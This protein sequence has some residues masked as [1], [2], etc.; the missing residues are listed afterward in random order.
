MYRVKTILFA[1]VALL[2]V[3]G[4][5]DE[6]ST[7]FNASGTL[8]HYSPLFTLQT[9]DEIEDDLSGITYNTE[10]K[11]FFMVRDDEDEGKIWEYDNNLHHLRT[12][13][14]KHF[15]DAEDIAYLGDDEFAIVNEAGELFIFVIDASTNTL[16][17]SD[18]NVQM[19]KFADVE[20]ENKGPEGVTYDSANKTFYIVNEK[21]PKALYYFIRPESSVTSLTPS[22][23]F[24]T[25]EVLE[26]LD[27]LSAITYD[28][29]NDS[30]LILSHQSHK[31][32]NVTK[33]GEIIGTLELADSTQHE[34]IALDDSFDLYI[35]SEDN[36]IR[37][38]RK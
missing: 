13:E 29:R 34:G 17:A 22:I 7:S 26:A 38:Y 28:S 30:L 16:D 27:D 3:D 35:T 21:K 25:K 15:G 23:L 6:P 12:I 2:F 18:E 20:V 5:S 1:I 11:T 8:A 32:L 9:L 4:C 33:E 24:D 19:I 14:T 31:V 10:S 36:F 37:L